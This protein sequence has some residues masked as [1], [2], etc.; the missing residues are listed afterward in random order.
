[1]TASI[2]P[3]LNSISTLSPTGCS[4]SHTTSDT[5]GN[6]WA[7]ATINY[8]PNTAQVTSMIDANGNK[9]VYTIGEPVSGFS[10]V[11]VQD[12]ANNT[13]HTWI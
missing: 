7:T 10:V 1:M 12:S 11:Q 13:I 4:T 2:A 9:Q 5:A 6:I 3:L 8:D